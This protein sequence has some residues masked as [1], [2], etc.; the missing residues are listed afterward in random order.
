MDRCAVNLICLPLQV[1]D[2]FSLPA[3]MILSL[4][5]YFV[6]LTMICLVDGRFLLN[7]MGVLCASLIVKSV[8]P[9]VRKVFHYDLLT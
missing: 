9:Q 3:F 4:I 2:C 6:N 7:L 1:K 8:F 5:E